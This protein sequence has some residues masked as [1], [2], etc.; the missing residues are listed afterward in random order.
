MASHQIA[1]AKASF[2]AGL[3]RPDPT[4]VPRDE[5]TVFHTSLDRVLSHCSPANIQTCKA[6]LL[7]Y[8]ASSS[9]RVGGLAKY[10]V[11]QAG[12]L[13]APP[14]SARPKPS[15]QRRRLHILYLLNDLFHHSKYH[16]DTTATFSTVSGSLQPFMVDLLGHVAAY[17]R[18]QYPR[19]HRRLD[20]LLGIW[21]EHGYFGPDLIHKLR[22]VVKNAAAL[23]GAPPLSNDGWMDD[24]D[25]AKKLAGKDAPFIMPSTHGDPSTPYYDLPAGNLV[26]HIIP[27]SSI[28]LRPDSIKPLQFLAG[29][30][31]ET[32]V[33]ALKGFLHD[34]EQIY[35]TEELIKDDENIDIDELGQRVMRDEITGDILDGETYYGWSRAFC[36]QMKR[37]PGGSR[38]RS[39]SH[40]RDGHATKRRRYSDSS[41]S[42]ESRRSY[43][44]SRDRSRPDRREA[45][46]YGSRSPLRSRSS[47]R[48]RSPESP[49]SPRGP[50]PPRFPPPHQ[51]SHAP[52]PSLPTQPAP[53]SHPYNSQYGLSGSNFPPPPPSYPAAWP[54]APSPH[55][56]GIP[57]PPPGPGMPPSAFPPSFPG[58]PPMHMPPGQPLP[59]GQYHF[60]P[61]HSGGQ[62]GDSWGSQGGRNWR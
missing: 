4:S 52:P 29:P 16:M 26:P 9:N 20:D 3:L 47:R 14:A 21:S 30:A 31:D 8:V 61:P 58:P 38:S 60:P 51:S 32:L 33:K 25:P 34:V 37:T 57:F 36:Q 1:I 53:P 12:A 39:R 18:Q 54:P 41:M 43:S 24:A 19:H 35:G 15:P 17:D 22:E 23:G 42:D 5:I 56:P 28:P 50:S 62:H 45:R 40:S 11:A 6:W 27:N 2:S 10:L 59:P 49:Y 48:S 44:Q 7:Q 55:M 46:G 13:D